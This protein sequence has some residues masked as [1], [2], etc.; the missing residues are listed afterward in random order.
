MLIGILTPVGFTCYDGHIRHQ[1]IEARTKSCDLAFNTVLKL[2]EQL[3]SKG[4]Q[5]ANIVAGGV[6]YLPNS[7]ET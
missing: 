4:I 2:K 5:V 3:T 6:T 7:C 1:D